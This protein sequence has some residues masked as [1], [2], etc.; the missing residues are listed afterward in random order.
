[1]KFGTHNFEIHIT[2]ENPRENTKLRA[3]VKFKVKDKIQKT[4]NGSEVK[5]VK[6]A[7]VPMNNKF[8]E[9]LKN[10]QDLYQEFLDE[11]NE[12]GFRVS[13]V[14]EPASIVL[15]GLSGFFFR[16]RRCAA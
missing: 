13:E 1:M 2:G 11:D 3:F 16:R 6:L 8:T 12:I 7:V 14:P 15:L 5:T 9:K 4:K 10:D